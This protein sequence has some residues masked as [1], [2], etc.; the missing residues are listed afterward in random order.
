MTYPPGQ[1]FCHPLP[2]NFIISPHQPKIYVTPWKFY[3][4]SPPPPQPKIYFTPWKF[5]FRLGALPSTLRALPRPCSTGIIERMITT[6][7]AICR[8]LKRAADSL[9]NRLT[10]INNFLPV[11]A[12]VL[13]GHYLEEDSSK[14]SAAFLNSLAACQPL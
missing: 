5:Y 6:N 10:I 14:Y 3:Y 11:Q 1:N 7:K 4:V 9:R 8:D 12:G 2:G 13:C